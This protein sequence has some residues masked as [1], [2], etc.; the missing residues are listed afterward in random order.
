MTEIAEIENKQLLGKIKEIKMKISKVNEERQSYL[1]RNTSPFNKNSNY[2]DIE[3]RNISPNS[4]YQPNK[5]SKGKLKSFDSKLN[6]LEKIEKK[7]IESKLESLTKEIALKDKQIKILRDKNYRMCNDS[8]NNSEN[9]SNNEQNNSNILNFEEDFNITYNSNL[10]TDSD[11]LLNNENHIISSGKYNENVVDASKIKNYDMS[12]RYF[13][14]KNEKN[15]GNIQEKNADSKGE[16]WKSNMNYYS[17]F[18]KKPNKKNEL[19]LSNNQKNPN[20]IKNIK[21]NNY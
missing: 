2:L 11:A 13:Y 9:E 20:K 19:D 15:E 17:K 14:K 4:R 10:N 8:N 18:L 3:D 12:L 1:N 16:V 6:E 21:R 5:S 7:I